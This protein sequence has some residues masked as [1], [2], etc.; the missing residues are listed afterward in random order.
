MYGLS[1][2][3]SRS[4]HSAACSRSTIGA[5]GRKLSRILDLEVHRRLHA[6]RAGIAED[7][8]RA[9]ARGPNSIRPW[10][11][12]TTFSVGQQA[13]DV[14]EQLLLVGEPLGGFYRVENLR[15]R[16]GRKT[17]TEETSLSGSRPETA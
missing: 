4:N 12:P 17:G 9:Q 14:F 6:R 1:W 10:N 8:A 13:G 11:Q 7:A 16:F 5:K 2:P 3:G 15:D